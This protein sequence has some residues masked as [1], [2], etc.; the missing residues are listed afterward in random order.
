LWAEYEGD[1]RGRINPKYDSIFWLSCVEYKKSEAGI[2]G[3]YGLP[4]VA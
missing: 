2:T 3:S 4:E 1:K